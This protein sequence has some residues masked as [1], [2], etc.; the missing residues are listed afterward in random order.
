MQSEAKAPGLTETEFI[1]LMNTY[2]DMLYGL[3]RTLLNDP[4]MAYDAVQETFLKVW[5]K[6]T[7]SPQSERAWL[8]RIAVNLCHDYHR[9]RWFIH[10]DRRTPIEEMPLAAPDGPDREI[11][12]MVM[13]LPLQE[14]EIVLLYYWND[15]PAEEIAAVLHI[16]RSTVYRKLEKAKKRLK[17]EWEG[18]QEP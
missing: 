10:T 18:G 2:S 11:L 14:K 15:M 4:H 9:S 8:I 12:D 3:C 13:H 7:F 17:L 16:N 1:R 6:R 5:K